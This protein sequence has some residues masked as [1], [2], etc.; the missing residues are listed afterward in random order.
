MSVILQVAVAVVSVVIAAGMIVAFRPQ[1]AEVLSQYIVSLGFLAAVVG[2][3]VASWI[4]PAGWKS[5]LL[6]ASVYLPLFGGLVAGGMAFYPLETRNGGDIRPPSRPSAP[7]NALIDLLQRPWDSNNVHDIPV[8]PLLVRCSQVTYE[9]PHKLKQSIPDLGFTSHG[10]FVKGSARGVV[11]MVGT[12]AVVAFQGTDGED[13]IGDWFTN[14]DKT[15]ALPPDDPV[16]R[17]FLKA[18]R[19][20]A[21][22]I[23][24]ILKDNGITHVWITGHSLGGAMA[25]LCALD[26]DAFDGIEVRGVI[27]FGQ[28][29][30]LEPKFAR[31]ANTQLYGKFL[32][33]IHRDDIVPCVVPG[34][35]GG[36]SYV[37]FQEGGQ[38]FGE[39]LMPL[40][41]GPGG[42][43]TPIDENE[44]EGPRRLSN[45]DFERQQAQVRKQLQQSSD[46]SFQA[47]PNSTDHE[48]ERYV[49]VV[50]DYFGS[51][52][53]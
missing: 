46:G 14:L 9:Y 50:T 51:A 3:F 15:L 42:D 6:A 39:P 35:R 23:R 47:M 21:G 36:G 37:W 34:L 19:S 26:L 52:S 53:N 24:E 27:T 10:D 30:L 31:S 49:D 12:E 4:A 41:S 22:Q 18:Y 20:V 1:T 28:P 48:M 32:R 16:H 29:L 38:K 5:H 33:I 7:P 43:D 8:A 40:F 11:M 25:V 13:D 45:R 2:L 44:E 17:G